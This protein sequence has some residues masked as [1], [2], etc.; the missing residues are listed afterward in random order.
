MHECYARND[1]LKGFDFTSSLPIRATCHSQGFI[2]MHFRLQ[3]H[4]SIVL[5]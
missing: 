5:A 3:A 1:R 2:Y 4:I